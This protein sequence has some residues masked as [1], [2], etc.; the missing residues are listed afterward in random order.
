MPDYTLEELQEVHANMLDDHQRAT[1][2]ANARIAVLSSKLADVVADLLALKEDADRVLD[3]PRPELIG[4]LDEILER[5]AK[6]A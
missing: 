2:T 6:G 5:L 1:D 4:R 3:L